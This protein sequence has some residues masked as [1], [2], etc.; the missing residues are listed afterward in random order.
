[1][2]VASKMEVYILH[3]HNLGVTSARSAAFHTE[4]RAQRWFA[5]ANSGFFTDPV[6][7]V[8]KADSRCSFTF[9]GRCRR[10]RRH[11]DQFAART[12]LKI[13]EKAVIDLSL[14]GPICL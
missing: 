13:L 3:R 9:T 6:Q 11:K 8:A 5:N 14:V 1:M 4:A 10:D 12:V 7:S 2:H